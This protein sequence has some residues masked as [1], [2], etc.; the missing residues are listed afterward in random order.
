MKC[1]ATLAL[2]ISSGQA[3][4]IFNLDASS[5]RAAFTLGDVLHTVHGAFKVKRGSIQ[6]D[7]TTGSSS[8]EIVVDATS[9]ESGSGA[10]DK[11]MHRNILESRLFPE[12]T[13]VP[14]GLRGTVSPAGESKVEIDGTF[15]IHGSSH[16]LTA[17][18][19]VT[20]AG[21]RLQ[22][23]VH[24]VVP[25]VLWGMK[26][27]STLFLKVGETVDIDLDATGHITWP[28]RQP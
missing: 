26:N 24:F 20:V 8:G 13:F 27:P 15:T 9:G 22:T 10:R 14:S 3:Q 6:F 23:K 11:R 4:A 12:I 16:R 7:P 19:V 18:A 1:F 2:L 17:S 5:S 21:D 28:N 25:Y